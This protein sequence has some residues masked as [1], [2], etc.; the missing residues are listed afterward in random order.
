MARRPTR[1]QHRLFAAE[2]ARLEPDL[3][4]AFE[5][6]A[7]DLRDGAIWQDLID[8]LTRQ[9]IDAAIASLQVEPAAFRA[10]AQAKTAAYAEGG[11]L[12]A[13][14]INA[15][16]GVRIAFRF[17]MANP[18]AEAW[19]AENVG[20]EIVGIADDIRQVA[21]EVILDGYSAGRHPHAIARDIAG[22]V[23]N[24]QRQGGIVGLDAPRAHRLVQVTRGMETAEGVQGLVIKGRDGTLRLRYKTNKATEARIL[25]AYRRGEA[26]PAP[27]RELSARQFSN[28]LLKDRADT[29]AATETGQAVMSARAEE[30]RQ[31]AEK[32]G[33][34]VD[35]ITKTW[36]HGRGTSEQ[37]RPDHLAMNNATVQGL[38]T[39]FVFPDGTAKQ[40][41]LDGNGGA[42]HD[43]RC[44]CQTTFR[45]D[46]SRGLT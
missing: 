8:A 45:L 32:M 34:P 22:R 17:D 26:V 46:H 23:V 39:P 29:I 43:A 13:T 16:D 44:G 36:I 9:D 24:G 7:Q 40:H 20:R 31:A 42:K 27:D 11:A 41:A 37:F 18:R 3:R 14:T 28:M 5:A 4:A 21:R 1:N 10:F 38:D 6:G 33:Y 19:I 2:I 35:A 25:R 15:P 30:W 12:A